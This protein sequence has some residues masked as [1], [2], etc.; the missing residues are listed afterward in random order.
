MQVNLNNK[1]GNSSIECMAMMLT[2]QQVR[3]GEWRLTTDHQ[4]SQKHL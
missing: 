2:G 3:H 1:K 4:S